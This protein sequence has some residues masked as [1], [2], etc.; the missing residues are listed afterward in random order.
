MMDNS[1]SGLVDREAP[2]DVMSQHW[3]MI[4]DA[5]LEIL[6]AQRPLFPT[7]GQ[8]CLPDDAFDVGAGH[9]HRTGRELAKQRR[10]VGGETVRSRAL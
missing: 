6:V 9:A 8:P 7:R 2:S 10:R 1:V 4:A 3:P 5:C